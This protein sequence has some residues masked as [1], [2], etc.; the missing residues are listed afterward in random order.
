MIKQ[1]L[2][3]SVGQSAKLIQ[4][5]GGEKKFFHWLREHG[6]LYNDNEPYQIQLDKG[7]LL[8]NAHKANPYFP[9]MVTRGILKGLYALKRVIKKHFS[10]CKPSDDARN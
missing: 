5:L 8:T 7:R 6:Y 9:N 3:F 1:E 2:T 10:I 4:F